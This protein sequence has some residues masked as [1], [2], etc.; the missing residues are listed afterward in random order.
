MNSFN[1]YGFLEDLKT[2]LLSDVKNGYLTDT[3]EI[4]DYI[5]SYLDNSVIYYSDCF[6]ICKALNFTD[7]TNHEFGEINGICQA[8]YFALYD[9]VNE[10]FDQSEIEEAIEAKQ[11]EEN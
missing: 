8:A 2:D 3:N 4:W 6:D 9:W 10:E 7:F 5:H 11:L 1:K